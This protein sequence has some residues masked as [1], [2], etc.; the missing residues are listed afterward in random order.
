[1]TVTVRVAGAAETTAAVGPQ[2]PQ[3]GG[4]Q[5]APAAPP[6]ARRAKPAS[7][8]LIR[9]R[10]HIASNSSFAFPRSTRPHYHSVRFAT[11][12]DLFCIGNMPDPGALAK[13]RGWR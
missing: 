3:A 5:A 13:T 1:M 8:L 11:G 7:R 6:A 4:Q 2:P 9:L 10:R 12:T